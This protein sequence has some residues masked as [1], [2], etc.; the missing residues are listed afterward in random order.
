MK[1][2]DCE[3]ELYGIILNV[4]YYHQP[5]ESDVG[6]SESVEIASVYV[7]DSEIDIYEIACHHLDEIVK[8]VFESHS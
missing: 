5:E 8:L 6:L 3:I 7:I 2:L 1:K 4:F